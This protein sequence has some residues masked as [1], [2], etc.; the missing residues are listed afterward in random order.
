MLLY[1]NIGLCLFMCL[2]FKT[3]V[4]YCAKYYIICELY[5]TELFYRNKNTITYY[6]ITD[7]SEKKS[8]QTTDRSMVAKIEYKDSIR[9]M[10]S[11]HEIKPN[12]IEHIVLSP[13]LF[14]S[15]E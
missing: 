10:I 9:Y 4:Q 8:F 14:L 7:L 6:N 3:C 12:E 2:H 15:V 11:S 1:I 5:I 13:K